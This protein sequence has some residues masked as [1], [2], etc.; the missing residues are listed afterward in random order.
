MRTLIIPPCMLILVTG[1]AGLTL[2]QKSADQV[3][4]E[5]ALVAKK[6]SL[7]ER[8]NQVLRDENLQ[9]TRSGEMAK[10]DAE[11]KQTEFTAN[12]NRLT[13]EL[14]AA[15]TTIA[16]LNQKI[17]ILE[18]E[19][20]GKI[21]QL[22]QLNEQLTERHREEMGK[23][24][25][26][27]KNAQVEAARDKER[28]SREAAEKQFAHAKEVQELKTRLTEKEKEADELRRTISELRNELAAQKTKPAAK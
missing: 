23:L 9:L 6:T 2:S 26:E 1:C 16:N 19:S 8:E 18:S 5:R 11:R 20:G 28:A 22:T 10:A 13:G 12:L 17:A 4:A 27:L 24:T 15:E 25:G 14:K 7:L 3:A 21:K